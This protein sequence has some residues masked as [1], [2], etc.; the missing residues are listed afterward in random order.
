MEKREETY[1][2]SKRVLDPVDVLH[3]MY[4]EQFLNENQ[5]PLW[6][7]RGAD[8]SE[9]SSKARG[10]RAMCKTVHPQLGQSPS[11]SKR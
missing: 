11:N 1:Q 9:K 2:N 4:H 3:V 6:F 10:S 8:P 7:L 5:D